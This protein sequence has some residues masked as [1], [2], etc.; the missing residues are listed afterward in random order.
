MS[1]SVSAIGKA[2]AVRSS[3]A[4]QFSKSS[5]CLEPEESLR[6]AAAATIDKALEAQDPNLAVKVIASGSQG[7]KDYTARTGVYNTLGITIEPLHGFVE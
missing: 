3:I 4:D 6:Q 1:W 7:F 5:P 2:P